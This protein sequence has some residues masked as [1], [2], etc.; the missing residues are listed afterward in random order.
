[1]LL[2]DQSK[3]STE[4]IKEIKEINKRY[5]ETND[6]EDKLIQNLWYTGKAVLRRKFI[7]IKFTAENKENNKNLT[8]KAFR[9]GRTNEAQN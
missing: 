1:M 5:L 2:N 3:K 8:P 6:N 9:E 7:A 4:E